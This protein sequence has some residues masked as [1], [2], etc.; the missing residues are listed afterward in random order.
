MKLQQGTL[1]VRLLEALVLA[2][3]CG[4]WPVGSIR[5]V[6]CNI[7]PRFSTQ[8]YL[9][10]KFLFLYLGTF[11][12]MTSCLNGTICFHLSSLNRRQSKRGG[13]PCAFEGFCKRSQRKQVVVWCC[14]IVSVCPRIDKHVCPFETVASKSL[15]LMCGSRAG[16]SGKF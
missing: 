6:L 15:W 12:V 2:Q 14:V 8:K 13:F 11:P 4:V 10:C 3:L 16:L 1:F 9:D 5:R 7:L